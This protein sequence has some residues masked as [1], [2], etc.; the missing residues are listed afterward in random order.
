MVTRERTE[1]S[2]YYLTLLIAIYFPHPFP[3]TFKPTRSMEMEISVLVGI[4]KIQRLGIIILLFESFIGMQI[5]GIMNEKGGGVMAQKVIEWL[6]INQGFVMVLL[7]QVYVLATI[8]IVF[9]NSLS[10]RELKITREAETRPYVLGQFASFSDYINQLDFQLRNSGKTA[11]K[12]EEILITP[13][14]PISEHAGNIQCVKGLI[15]APNQTFNI[16]LIGEVSSLLEN[17]YS[18]HIKY[19]GLGMK[20]KYTEDYSIPLKAYS[21]LGHTYVTQPFTSGDSNAL[22]NIASVLSSMNKRI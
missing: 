21:L 9:F 5:Y 6:N 22:R 2:I 18:V 11:A 4:M 16:Q 12:I 13:A 15:I 17:T 8:I 19:Q 7:T 20:K 3:D 1:N 14:L 10:I